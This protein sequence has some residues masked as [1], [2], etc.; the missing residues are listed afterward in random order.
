MP[1]LWLNTLQDASSRRSLSRLSQRLLPQWP[2]TWMV[3]RLS[4]SKNII[5]FQHDSL[6]KIRRLHSQRQDPNARTA[7]VNILS[8]R[9]P[10][11]PEDI[12][13]AQANALVKAGSEHTSVF[14]TSV[15]YFLLTNPAK[16]RIVTEEIRKSFSK[17]HQ[18]DN[19]SLGNLKYL[20]AVIEEGLRILPASP[21]GAPCTSPGALVAHNYV[22]EGVRTFRYT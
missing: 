19:A 4:F 3:Q 11:E 14:L 12:R 17:S 22:P 15:T 20:A 16:L 5:L 10:H 13:A 7:F 6:Q 9:L 8:E 21:L 2:F 18:I 1:H